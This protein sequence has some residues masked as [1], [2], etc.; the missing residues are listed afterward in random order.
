[1]AMFTQHPAH[2]LGL[3]HCDVLAGYG[4]RLG[5]IGHV[6]QR[7]ASFNK[8]N[9]NSPKHTAMVRGTDGSLWGDTVDGGAPARLL[10]A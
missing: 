3:H 8:T 10:T 7:A 4:G 9:G 6:Q 1:M 5:C 2:S